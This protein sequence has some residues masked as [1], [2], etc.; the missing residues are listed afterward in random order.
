MEKK[1]GYESRV[2]TPQPN[3]ANREP[4]SPSI[5]RL[6]VAKLYPLGENYFRF[7]TQVQSHSGTTAHTICFILKLTFNICFWLK[8]FTFL[9]SPGNLQTPRY[10]HWAPLSSCVTRSS[11]TKPS[12]SKYVFKT[13][14][15]NVYFS[16]QN[17]NQDISNKQEKQIKKTKPRYKHT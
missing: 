17:E 10:L 13:R 5:L 12:N 4:Q 6:N 2:K 11:V 8:H 15:E 3:C 16:P 1:R 7:F 14:Q 9:P